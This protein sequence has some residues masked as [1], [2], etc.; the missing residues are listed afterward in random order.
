MLN[1]LSLIALIV[2]R[3][4]GRNFVSISIHA[5]IT[6]GILVT[7]Y[8]HYFNDYGA[9]DFDGYTRYSLAQPYTNLWES[10]PSE[11]S[12][13]PRYAFRMIWLFYPIAILVK[14]EFI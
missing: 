13:N 5:L 10:W 7:V 1:L 12:Q 11:I 3:L 2:F 9:W 4:L 14:N 6:I 8:L